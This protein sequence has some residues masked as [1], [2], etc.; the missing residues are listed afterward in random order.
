MEPRRPRTRPVSEPRLQRS[1]LAGIRQIPPQPLAGARGSE[2][3]RDV[4]A[5]ALFP[6]RDCK[7]AVL[8]GYDRFLHNRLLARAALNGSATSSHAP[9]FRAA[10]VKERS[11]RDTTDSSTTA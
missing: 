9:C 5:R 3:S 1:G 7:G 2:W 11:C 8:P 6:S 10:T 4:I